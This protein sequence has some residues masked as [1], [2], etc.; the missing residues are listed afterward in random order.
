MFVLSDAFCVCGST[1]AEYQFAL[2]G[3]KY[4]YCGMLLAAALISQLYK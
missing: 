2:F 4:C 3:M 1:A